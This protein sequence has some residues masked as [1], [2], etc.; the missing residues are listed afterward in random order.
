VAITANRWKFLERPLDAPFV[1][2]AQPEVIKPGIDGFVRESIQNSFDRRVAN[3]H[4]RVEFELKELEGVELREFLEF[5]NW[6]TL[7]VQLDAL[8][9][10]KNHQQQQIAESLE[11]LRSGKIRLLV[12][13]DYGTEGLSGPEF[14]SQGVNGNFTKFGRDGM[15]PTE[16]VGGGAFGVGKSV[17]WNHSRLRTVI[18][19][20]RFLE[21]E[22]GQTRVFGRAYL[23]D[24]YLSTSELVRQFEGHGFWCKIQDEMMHSMNFDEAGVSQDSPL[25][26]LWRDEEDFGTTVVSLM[27]DGG[28]NSE[29]SLEQL[30]IEIRDA[31]NLNFWPLLQEDLVDVVVKAP[32]STFVIDDYDPLFE[33]FVRASLAPV[34]EPTGGRLD[35][36]GTSACSIPLSIAIPKRKVHG[37]SHNALSGELRLGVTLLSESEV[38]GLTEFE[39]RYSQSGTDV[40]LVNSTSFVR[41]PR[42]VVRYLNQ[43]GFDFPYVAVMKGGNFRV[44]VDELSENDRNVEVFLRDSEPPAHNFWGWPGKI[45]VNYQIGWRVAFTNMRADLSKTLRSLLK[46][47]IEGNS[48]IPEGLAKLL[49]GGRSGGTNN[50]P[51]YKIVS[52]AYQFLLQGERA[53]VNSTFKVV[54]NKS[55]SEAKD[56]T[57]IVR[58]EA[59][60]EQGDSRLPLLDI[61]VEPRTGVGIEPVVVDAI[62]LEYRLLVPAA[63]DSVSV[64]LVG[65]LESFSAIIRTKL[66][67][68]ATQSSQQAIIARRKP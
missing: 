20:S 29:Q 56:W 59:K 17:F 48:D 57:S 64:S 12:V 60:G 47:K 22:I 67:V 2:G 51:T 11:E 39:T 36:D 23:P 16:G 68:E 30:A 4:V 13:R 35:P 33:P 46:R 8:A 40:R 65:S 6:P 26:M 41:G 50:G 55:K 7:E 31:V 27:F 28:G 62:V 15:V 38:A 66:R 9:S 34:G 58:I 53:T 42:M 19:S 37:D 61:K 3:S 25:S 21:G 52:P 49:N 1:G 63:I 10:Q 18:M 5:V 24:H 44:P 54:R 32:G 45:R 14:S 43:S